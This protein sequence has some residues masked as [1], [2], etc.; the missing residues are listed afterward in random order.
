MLVVQSIKKRGPRGDCCG[1]SYGL[2]RRTHLQVQACKKHI[3]PHHTTSHPRPAA[4]HQRLQLPRFRLERAAR[5]G[6]HLASHEAVSPG[7]FDDSVTKSSYDDSEGHDGQPACGST[8]AHAPCRAC[9]RFADR[10]RHRHARMHAMGCALLGCV[11]RRRRCPRSPRRTCSY[12]DAA[13]SSLDS[14]TC[15]W[16]ATTAAATRREGPDTHARA[17]DAGAR[18]VALW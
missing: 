7:M 3:T 14:S 15:A 5:D 2:G 4:Q 17:R 13:K 12:S 6:H 9:P 8:A 16:G 10:S 11:H 1:A 18:A